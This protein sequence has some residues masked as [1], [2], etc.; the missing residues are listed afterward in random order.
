MEVHMLHLRIVSVLALATGAGFCL[1]VGCG[2]SDTGE[3]AATTA[4][5][6]ASSGGGG[7][8]GGAGG[9]G[10]QGGQGGTAGAPS[11]TNGNDT[12]LTVDKFYLG[13]ES[14]E[15]MPDPTNGWRQFGY[16]LDGLTT[17]D[18]FTEHC[19]PVV[20]GDPEMRL[21][22]GDG[23]IDNSF[24]HN[25]LPILLNNTPSFTVQLND[26]IYNG[27]S[28]VMFKFDELGPGADQD[29]VVTKLYDVTSVKQANCWPVVREQ[30]EDP[31]DIESTPVVFLDA[32]VAGHTWTSGTPITVTVTLNFI[33]YPMKLTIK[34]ARLSMEL[35][36]T[37]KSATVGQIGGVLDTEEFLNAYKQVV[38]TVDASFCADFD[39]ISNQIRPLS[40]IMTDGTQDPQSTCNGI[41]I[42]IGFILSQA[43][44]GGIAPAGE[45][46]DLTC[47]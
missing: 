37:H 18:D 8:A 26:A 10:G 28:T 43:R 39:T 33:G 32:S 3:A 13:D 27:E 6:S 45:P 11:C 16:D 24:G 29:P 4:T 7:G 14:F 17:V 47:P 36:P 46:V 41:S 19:Q 25:M 35:D 22:D 30:L 42:G 15:D 9:Q 12:V 34:H 21:I 44:I 5:S 2:S 31:T 20:A 23:G 1:S 40:D 38:G